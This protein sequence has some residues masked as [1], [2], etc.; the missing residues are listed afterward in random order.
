M[1]CF[2]KIIFI[3]ACFGMFRNVPCSEFYRRSTRDRVGNSWC[4]NDV[5]WCDFLLLPP[6][7]AEKIKNLLLALRACEKI[8]ARLVSKSRPKSRSRKLLFPFQKFS[9]PVPLQLVPTV[10]MANG[11]ESVYVSAVCVSFRRKT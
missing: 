6:F 2:M 11:S 3:F 1:F 9:F 5:T 7:A 4:Q 10:K 8:W